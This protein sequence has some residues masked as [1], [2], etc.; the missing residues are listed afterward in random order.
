M[1]INNHFKLGDVVS[2]ICS[3]DD[4]K[5]MVVC[6]HA[7][8]SGSLTYSVAWGDRGETVHFAGELKLM[9]TQ[10]NDLIQNQ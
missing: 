9:A 8:L 7:Q 5:G 10:E 3:A 2:L 6:I 1:Q 4:A